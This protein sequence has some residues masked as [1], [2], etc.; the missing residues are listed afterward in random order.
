[1][2]QGRADERGLKRDVIRIVLPVVL[3]GGLAVVLVREA[4]STIEA[5]KARQ[6]G[7]A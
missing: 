1:M 2:G 4:I 3:L 7:A 5:Q 6:E